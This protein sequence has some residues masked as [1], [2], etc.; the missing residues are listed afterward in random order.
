MKNTTQTTHQASS[1]QQMLVL[2]NQLLDD[3]YESF[4]ELNEEQSQALTYLDIHLPE[5]VDAW[6][7]TLMK[8]GGIDKDIELLQERKSHIQEVINQLKRG[9]ERLKARAN[10]ILR[11]NSLDRIEGSQFWFKREVST[12]TSVN[13]AKVEDSYKTFELPKLSFQE[14]SL[15]ITALQDVLEMNRIQYDMEQLGLLGL[16][17]KKLQEEKSESCGVKSLPAN[18]PALEVTETPTIRIYPQR[19]AA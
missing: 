6:A 15:L 13:L 3:I 17:L 18:H 5:K 4:G 11:M 1:L 10:Q 19:K 7:W 8:G 14:Y 9:K 12:S 2:K 16:L